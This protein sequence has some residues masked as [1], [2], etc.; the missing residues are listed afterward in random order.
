M[1][2][3]FAPESIAALASRFR[4]PAY[5]V[6]DEARGGL[7]LAAGADP[8]RDVVAVLPPLFPEWLGDRS[9]G[10]AHGVRFPYVAGEMANGIATA[11]LV[12]AM[13]EADMLGFFGAAGLEVD[14][15]ERA[16]EKLAAALPG[17]GNWGVNFIHSPHSLQDEERLVDMLLRRGVSRVS[18]SAFMELT[19]AVV[20]L[21]ASGLHADASGRIR[22]RTH[23]FAK[24]SR[25]EVAEKFMSPA[26]AGVLDSL[27]A[28][29]R[30]TAE[31]AALAA[32]V[33]I[34]EDVTVEAD[35]GGHTV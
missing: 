32:R 7:G 14:R 13:A 33:P 9:F 28:A 34:A 4:E 20:R 6:S 24:V 27:A 30:L 22:R 35:S 26:P 3:V 15:V 12:T 2:P 1:N 31:E 23:L 16:V 11:E 10:E 29:G 21:A 8:G 17:R 5:V 18:C 19:P 25:P